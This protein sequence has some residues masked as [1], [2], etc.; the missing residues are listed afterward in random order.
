MCALFCFGTID[1]EK[2]YVSFYECRG[3]CVSSQIRECDTQFGPFENKRHSISF[4]LVS[5]R[6]TDTT[7][8]RWKHD[9][10]SSLSKS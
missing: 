8:Q 7:I 9:T 10:T 3:F 2:G 6:V 1:K 5:G 4:P